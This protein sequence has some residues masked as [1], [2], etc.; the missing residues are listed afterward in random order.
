[1]ARDALI[2]V[3]AAESRIAYA[4]V[5]GSSA[6]GTAHAGSD[7]DIG[8]GLVAGTRLEPLELGALVS[9]LEQAAQ[10]DVDLVLLDEAPPGVAYRAFR[11][12]ELVLER[13]HARLAERKARAILEYLDFEPV[14]RA[15]AEGALRAAARGR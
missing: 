13:D 4:L 7:L 12:G 10:R 3:L 8:V 5:F 2:Q 14:E 9:R 15:L 11:D 6:R 1:M